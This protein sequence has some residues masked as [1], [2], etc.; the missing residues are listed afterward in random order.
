MGEID[1]NDL[2]MGQEPL[3]IYN[4]N[5]ETT[6]IRAIVPKHKTA[7]TI[8]TVVLGQ[9]IE[10]VKGTSVYTSDVRLWEGVLNRIV[11]YRT[12]KKLDY[13]LHRNT[14]TI[15]CDVNAWEKACDLGCEWMVTYAEAERTMLVCHK[16]WFNRTVD[17]GHGKQVRA[18]ASHC[19]VFKSSTPWEFK[20]P[21]TI[22]IVGD[23]F[24][25]MQTITNK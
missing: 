22:Y 10:G 11:F 23:T 17:W 24:H 12:L 19:M 14:N 15:G 25:E 9:G 21:T 13:F 8:G 20:K 1:M 2:F 4:K 18:L 7:Q 5:S 3:P 16:D 6:K